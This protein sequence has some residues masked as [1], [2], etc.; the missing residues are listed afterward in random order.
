MTELEKLT[1]LAEQGDADAQDQLGKMYYWGEGV[2]K[3]CKEAVECFKKAAK[4]GDADAQDRLS[5]MCEHGTITPKDYLKAA[6][7]GGWNEE[8]E[9]FLKWHKLEAKQNE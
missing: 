1:K 8:A 4:Q 6:E 7:R 3:D 5:E 9:R 2:E